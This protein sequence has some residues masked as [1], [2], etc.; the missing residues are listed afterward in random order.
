MARG[1]PQI[2]VRLP[3]DVRDFIDA[4]VAENGSSRTFEVVRSIRQR[5]KAKG[6]VGSAI[7]PSHDQNPSPQKDKGNDA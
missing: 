5:M 4:E 1:E 3:T 7:P 2:N 6:P